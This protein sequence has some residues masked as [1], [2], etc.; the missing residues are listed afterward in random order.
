MRHLKSKRFYML[1]CMIFSVGCSGC[2]QKVNLEDTTII[3]MLGVDIND[4]GHLVLYSSSPVFD[5][6]VPDN[7]EE[8]SV[9]APSIREAR[10]EF[11]SILSGITSKGKLQILLIGKK[12]LENDKWIQLLDPLY[13]DATSSINCKVL[14]VDE[15][16][17]DIMFMNPSDKIRLS[18]HLTKLMETGDLRHITEI[19]T[20]Q[21]LQIDYLSK[22]K[23]AYLPTISLKENK[24]MLN[25][26]SMLGFDG[27]Y[28]LNLN[29]YEGQ[30]LQILRDQRIE[31]LIL[32]TTLKESEKPFQSQLISYNVD[33]V[34]RS[35]HVNYQHGRF[36]FDLAY[37]LPI[38][39][40]EAFE[41]DIPKH[42]KKIEEDIEKALNDHMN[43]LL[44]T[45]KE[46]QIDPIG[47]GEYA[48]AYKYDYWKN[49]KDQ[50]GE[51]FS[52][53]DINLTIEV[54]IHNDGLTKRSIGNKDMKNLE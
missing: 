51:E 20:I 45:F 53:S 9:I 46:K 50:W 31:Q 14:T 35:I 49:V 48:R 52:R 12:V 40:Y 32:T 3:L 25:G 27:T 44:T 42:R 29:Q 37:R 33:E 19:K 2:Q 41:L 21:D 17:E 28:I 13:R 4:E 30:L 15:N 6:E 23:S 18:L 16:V 36:T 54:D 38:T 8:Y 24:I 1:L 43:R 11:D 7:N 34:K 26:F 22:A 39:I 10:G 47:L 5:E